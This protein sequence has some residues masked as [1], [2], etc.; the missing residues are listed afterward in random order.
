MTAAT[1]QGGFDDP[2]FSE[3]H[4]YLGGVPRW[5]A[6]TQGSSNRLYRAHYEGRALMLRLNASPEWTPGVS[7][8]VE[9]QVLARIQGHCWA[10]QVLHNPWRQGWCLMR[11]HGVPLPAVGT[12][13]EEFMVTSLLAAIEQ[14]QSLQGLPVEEDARLLSRYRQPLGRHPLW[15]D[16]IKRGER[17]LKALPLLPRCLTHHDL[18][19]GNLCGEQGQ[20]VV[21][22]WEYAACG[23]PWFDGAA[24]QRQFGV[25]VQPIAEL[26]AWRGLSVARCEEG[27]QSALWLDELLACLWY[28]VRDDACGGDENTRARAELLLASAGPA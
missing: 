18:H 24:L 4:D 19:R 3:V 20:W 14:W 17:V 16:L 8:S 27:L 13:G 21:L 9:A 25:G 5:Q 11:D 28:A 26:P 10:P 15:S 12:N 22:D 7:R 1:E 6:L 23:N 2:R